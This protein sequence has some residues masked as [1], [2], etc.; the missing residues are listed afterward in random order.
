MGNSNSSGNGHS[1][2]QANIPDGLTEMDSVYEIKMVAFES[3]CNDGKG[4]S[5]GCHH[6][7]EYFAAVKEEHE[8]AAGLFHQNCA[9][10]DFYPSC[11]NLARAYLIGRGVEQSDKQ[12]EALYGKACKGGHLISCDHQATLLYSLAL[13]PMETSD[14]EGTPKE[15]LTKA[16]QIYEDACAAGETDSCH[17]LGFHYMT[18]GDNRSPVKA[19]KYLETACNINHAPSCAL[20]AN[21]YQNGDD[22][23]LKDDEKGEKYASRRDSLVKAYSAPGA[24]VKF[25]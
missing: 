22:G 20:L 19:L 14:L 16:V 8:R 17:A 4:D 25:D 18:P 21:I 24:T 9:E 13:Q 3:D 10:K 23:V 2:G 6:A 7:A 1:P 12:S 5:L 11:F 15:H